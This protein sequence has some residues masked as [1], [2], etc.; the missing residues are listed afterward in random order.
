[1]AFMDN[2]SGLVVILCVCFVQRD[3]YGIL[4]ER[5][6]VWKADLIDLRD[7]ETLIVVRY[8]TI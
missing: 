1:M 8:K 3:G 4:H 6:G 2:L 5:L 7:I